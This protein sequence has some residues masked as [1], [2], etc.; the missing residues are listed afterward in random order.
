MKNCRI[1]G[2]V[3]SVAVIGLSLSACSQDTAV[4]GS[5]PVEGYDRTPAVVLEMPLGFSNV[6][7]HCFK[8]NGVYVTE[9]YAEAPS[10]VSTVPN[11]P[12]CA[13]K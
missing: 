13:N 9:G 10:S 11:D 6:A 3:L 2:I 1:A 8:G 7:V 4:G 12:F 5:G